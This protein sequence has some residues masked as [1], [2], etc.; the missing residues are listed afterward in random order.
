MYLHMYYFCYSFDKTLQNDR[1]P[2]IILKFS[3]IAWELMMS[4]CM[5]HSNY[6]SV[7]KVT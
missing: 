6:H 5:F 3:G 1:F 4:I 7:S 2:N